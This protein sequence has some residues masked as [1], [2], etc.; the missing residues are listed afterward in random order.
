MA[1][2][3]IINPDYS[4]A[5]RFL[6]WSAGAINKFLFKDLF[7]PFSWWQQCFGIFGW[8][9]LNEDREFVITEFEGH[10]LLWQEHDSC[11]WT[12]GN[13]FSTSTKKVERPCKGKINEQYCEADFFNSC[14]KEYNTW[15]GR[16]AVKLTPAGVTLV[17]T[18]T[19]KIAQWAVVGA[20]ATLTAGGY[21]DPK[22]VKFS[23][24]RQHT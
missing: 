5:D 14:F 6:T 20:V 2:D 11:A 4:R 24:R 13:G 18:I 10:G 7:D 21:L 1:N 9:Q 23:K 8:M 22:E 15:D 19:T 3:F 12:P 17:N 16:G